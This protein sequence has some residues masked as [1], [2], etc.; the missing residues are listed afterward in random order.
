VRNMD[1]DTREK[2][3][4]AFTLIPAVQRLL[5]NEEKPLPYARGLVLL[6]EPYVDGI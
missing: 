3:L 5:P 1:D 6:K 4:V 2:Q